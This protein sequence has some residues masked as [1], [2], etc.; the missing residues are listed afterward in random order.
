MMDLAEKR[1]IL[2]GAGGGIGRQLALQLARKG[3]RLLLVDR[4]QER[5]ND[6]GAEVRAAHGVVT[7]LAVD[8][9]R[10]DSHRQVVDMARREFGGIDVLINN[11]GILAFVAYEEQDPAQIAAIINVNATAAMLLTRAVLPCMLAQNSGCIVNIGSTFGSIG[12]PYFAAYSASKFAVR[13]FS[14]ALR[15]ELADTGIEVTFVSPRA[16]Q[17]AINTDAVNRML[18]ET[19]ANTDTP[20]YVAAQVVKAIESGRKDCYIGWPESFF[21]RLNGI[22]PRLVDVGLRRQAR[23]ARAYARLSR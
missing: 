21:A 1:V 5:L 23:I 2:T 15:R 16:T 3:A 4:G 8:L 10:M 11:A 14:E 13:G 6:V 20:K 22:A 17:T 18:A 19:G 7:T 12:F 9:A